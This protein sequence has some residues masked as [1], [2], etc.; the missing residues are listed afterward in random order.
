M[1][2]STKDEYESLKFQFGSLKR[3]EYSKYLPLILCFN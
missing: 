3:G 1:K 2:E